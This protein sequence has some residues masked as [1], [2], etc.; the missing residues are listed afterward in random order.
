MAEKPLPA[1]SQAAAPLPSEGIETQFQPSEHLWTKDTD[2]TL[3]ALSQLQILKFVVI[4][5]CSDS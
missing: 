3:S 2:K 5:H 4:V 1:T